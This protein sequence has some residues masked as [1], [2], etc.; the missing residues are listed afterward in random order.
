LKPRSEEEE[1]LCGIFANL[2]HLE[3]VEV[4]ANFFDLGGH[5][6]LAT[7]LISRIRSVFG[8][9]LPVRTLFESPTVSEITARIRQ[10]QN[11]GP[12]AA[13]PLVGVSRERNLPL[14]YAQQ[15]LW[16]LHQMQPESP[17]YNIPFALRLTGKLDRKALQSSL[18]AMVERHETLRTSFPAHQGK[19]VQK[20]EPESQVS[21][22]E[23]DLRHLPEEQREAEIRQKVLEQA[24]R[25]FDLA[26]GPLLRV[27]LLQIGEEEHALLVTLHH[28]VSDGWSVAI[29]V[30][31]FCAF[32]AAHVK[33][34][35]PN[36]PKLK[37]QYADFSVWQRDWL[38]G[39]VLE[40][41]I[42]YWKKQLTGASQLE[43]PT[44]FARTT[45]TNDPAGQEI[46]DLGPELTRSLMRLSRQEGVTQF[47]VLLAAY[48]LIL[49]R[50]TGK[51][52]I[53]VGTDIANRNRMETEG[54]IGFFVNQLVLR[55]N[56][57]RN[58]SFRELLGRVRDTVLGAYEHQDLPFDKVVEAL[59]PG[60]D[61]GSTPLFQVKLV[62]QNLPQEELM[63]PELTVE[64]METYEA[65]AKFDILL[66]MAETK[67]GLRGW[68]RYNAALFTAASIRS[69]Q[70]FFQM[71][72]TLIAEDE[73]NLELP[74]DKFLALLERRVHSLVEQSAGSPGLSIAKRRRT[75]L[76]AQV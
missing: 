44:D 34:E 27:A 1:I 69:F 24:N 68:T 16:F 23:I 53:C 20:I 6:L 66:T 47:I 11:K 55:T 56:L 45:A 63:L 26:N 75:H 2:L 46:F 31:E 40:E 60:R 64:Q 32:Y 52:D 17:A 41:Q 9:E 58:P 42:A 15:R 12:A 25:P 70:H 29:I 22:E 51:Q 38:Q 62:L 43:L 3:R 39:A 57:S 76:T 54:L 4:G 72:L 13:P 36:L 21:V 74:Q 5:S 18:C 59:M 28:I 61:A 71:A 37:I 33:G 14:S 19:P 49:A 30:K 10:T 65:A 8:V 48:Q 73:A 50:Y 67:T 7:Q 35:Q